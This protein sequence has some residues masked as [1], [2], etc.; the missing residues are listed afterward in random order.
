MEALK[1]LDASHNNISH[2][3]DELGQLED[4]E[5][6]LMQH[7]K[8]Q[9]VPNFGNN[10][11][12]RLLDLSHNQLS[13]WNH[14]PRSLVYLNMSKN[15]LVEVPDTVFQLPIIQNL[16]LS[17]NRIKKIGMTKSTSPY[18]RRKLDDYSSDVSYCKNLKTLDLSNNKFTE[19]PSYFRK[20]VKVEKLYL[21]VNGFSDI[22]D[23]VDCMHN[24]LTLDISQ[25]QITNAQ[26]L[27]HLP[28]SIQRLTLNHNRLESCN[29][30]NFRERGK[31]LIEFFISDNKLTCL[32]NDIGLCS[33]L[34]T[35]DCSNNALN[36]LPTS[37]A[38]CEKLTHIQCYGNPFQKMNRSKLNRNVDEIKKY[39]ETRKPVA[40]KDKTDIDDAENPWKFIIRDVRVTN[41]LDLIDVPE[42]EFP[43]E[44][45]D[46]PLEKLT[47]SKCN[48]LTPINMERLSASIQE[49]EISNMNLTEF[50]AN[51][52]CCTQLTSLNL[53]CNRISRLPRDL[54]SLKRI[55]SMNLSQNRLEL[56]TPFFTCPW[57]QD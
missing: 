47:I 16:D 17:F 50:S 4:M 31:H 35:L 5:V 41:K 19:L 49:L 1:K 18:K 29:D 37:L 21:Q 57:I 53:S 33:N 2:T 8:L 11:R 20:L 24:L 32:S 12:L 3:P 27:K 10:E 43:K 52:L 9:I 6:F 48:L 30:L 39:L 45:W 55:K 26:S 25:N 28:S 15:N 56:C 34:A 46:I 7:N 54:S 44:L 14:L 13:M 38:D 40:E 42:V 23:F 22:P 51:L 36:E